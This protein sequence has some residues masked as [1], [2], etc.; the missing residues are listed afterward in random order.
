MA[1]PEQ[2]K[3]DQEN[4]NRKSSNL[5]GTKPDS[6]SKSK[7]G[8][9]SKVNIK[10]TLSAWFDTKADNAGYNTQVDNS[11][12]LEA[13]ESDNRIN[14]VRVLPFIAMHL[15]VLGVIWVGFSW[16]AFW[17]AVALYFVRMFAI[18]GFY[19]RYFSHKNFKTSRWLQFIFAFIAASSA[20]R[21]PLWWASHHREH[22]AH[23]D[24]ESDPHSPR[25]HGFLWSHTLWFL[26]EKNFTTRKRRIK[27]FS[28]FKELE[29]LDRF[30][31]AAPAALA[32]L[33]YVVGSLLE[34]YAPA[35]NTSGGQLVIWG[36]FISTVGLYHATYTINSLAHR[37]G[38][39]RFNT[40][41]DSRNN[42]LL[43][44]I[45]LGEG[46]HNNHHYFSGTVKQGFRWWEI[47]ITYYLLKLMSFFGLVWDLK[48]IPARVKQQMV[49]SK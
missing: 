21:G 12:G 6:S 24:K 47:D 14:W 37:F 48:P 5:A 45:T 19:H 39:R 44:L 10:S 18:T 9:K 32:L 31:I 2:A 41:D 26:A 43:A 11:E 15:A 13:D 8:F 46:W 34:S 40:P 25:Q 29:W 33:L 20:Q 36:F 35:L 16:F 28:R 17:V 23:S 22:H 4:S 7:L 38:T 49:G 1:T 3:L 42:A 27:D 30:D